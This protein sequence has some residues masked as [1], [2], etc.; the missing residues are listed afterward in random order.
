[1]E[2]SLLYVNDLDVVVHE[3]AREPGGDARPVFAGHN[4]HERILVLGHGVYLFPLFA[5]GV[6]QVPAGT[7]NHKGVQG[8]CQIPAVLLRR[9]VH[10]LF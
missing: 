2:R 3:D 1:V 10:F 7:T 9:P 8:L 6:A 4:H 5:E